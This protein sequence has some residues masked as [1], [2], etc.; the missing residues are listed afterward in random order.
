M[1]LVVIKIVIEIAVK[2]NSV[3]NLH[4]RF[5]NR[6]IRHK[7]YHGF[8]IQ[9]DRDTGHLSAANRYWN[10]AGCN[11]HQRALSTSVASQQTDYF[12]SA[13]AEGYVLQRLFGTVGFRYSLKLQYTF[14]LVWSPS[15]YSLPYL[16]LLLF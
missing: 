1:R 12:T 3:L 13:N 16:S 9:T 14:H 5:C 7:G 15:K 6:S 11:F 8:R 4:P 10:Q 2:L